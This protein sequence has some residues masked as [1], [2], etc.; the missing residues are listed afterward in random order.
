MANPGKTA[1]IYACAMAGSAVGAALPL[2]MLPRMEEAP[3]MLWVSLIPLLVAFFPGK[4]TASNGAGGSPGRWRF[5]WVFHCTAGL[6]VLLLLAS[7]WTTGRLDWFRISPNP[8]KGLSQ[9]MM[10]PQTRLA[11]SDSGIRGRIDRVTSPHI[12]FAPGLSLKFQGGLPSQWAVFT[13]GDGRLVFYDVVDAASARFARFSHLY[14][15]Y[16]LLPDVQDVLVIQENGGFAVTCALASGAPRITVLDADP[17]TTGMVRDHYRVAATSEPPLRFFSRIG[18]RFDMIH[19]ENWGN[20][21]PGT[22]ALDQGHSL[23]RESISRYLASL[24]DRGI[25]MVSRMLHLPPSDMPRLWATAYECL[26][27]MGIAEPARHMVILRNW[28]TFTLIVSPGRIPDSG[29]IVA[30]A[31]KY[32]FDRVAGPASETDLVNR[33]NKFEKA[34]HHLEIKSLEDAYALGEERRYFRSYPLDVRPQTADRPFP[35]RF[36]KWL[37][38]KEIYGMSGSRAGFLA[39]SG[40]IIVGAVLVVA[41]AISVVLL[42]L[43]LIVATGKRKRP[44][45]G[46][47]VYFLSVGAGFMFME[48]YFIKL[49]Y[50]LWSSPAISLSVVLAGFLIFSGLGGLLSHRI[51][52]AR[53][54]IVMA[55]IAAVVAVVY[56]GY[57][58]LMAKVGQGGGWWRVFWAVVLLLPPGLVMGIP[59]PL[60]M[61]YMLRQPLERAY[62][63]SANGCAS[64]AAAILSA[65]IA[66]ST[67]I[68]ALAAWAAASYILAFYCGRQPL[69]E[70]K[71]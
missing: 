33:F 68:S 26:R 2:V 15:G 12:R 59:F 28:D 9:V 51:D 38:F 13:D 42:I 44:G 45:L 43:P 7:L 29:T 21:L 31:R 54:P 69:S 4:G 64:V 30:F 20:S 6:A 40:E 49:Y 32:N 66:L 19:L 10:Y 48:L 35:N 22:A 17:R 1:S 50:Q 53:F 71:K 37:R 52:P 61:R 46:P 65:Q 63:W 5:R 27:E 62:A 25:F 36:F 11:D 56:F 55:V 34:F 14:A 24:T 16:L 18:N 41:L 67:N 47:I 3:A 58:H 60:G 8:Y 70:I 23:T 57:G 39:L